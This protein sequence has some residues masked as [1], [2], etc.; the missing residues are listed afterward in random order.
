[1][2]EA[3]LNLSSYSE[4]GDFKFMKLPLRKCADEDAYIEIGIR[5]LENT[6]NKSARS[7]G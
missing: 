3:D 4:G 7:S 6:N 2:G 1:L 5:G